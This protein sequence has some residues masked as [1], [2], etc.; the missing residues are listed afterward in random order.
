MQDMTKSFLVG[1][2]L[3]NPMPKTSRKITIN[4]VKITPQNGTC[5]TE[6]IP[7]AKVAS[8]PLAEQPEVAMGAASANIDHPPNWHRPC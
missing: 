2:V 5:C 8:F 3:V 1:F 4:G 6:V 7:D